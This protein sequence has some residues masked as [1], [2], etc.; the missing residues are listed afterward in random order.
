[1]RIDVSFESNGKSLSG[2]LYLPDGYEAGQTLPGV[3]VTGA[4]TTVKEQMPAIYAKAIS[5]R[6]FAALAFDFRGWGASP[7][8]VSYLEDPYRKTADILAATEYLNSRPE[9]DSARIAGLGICASSGYMSDAALKSERIQSL[10]LVAPWLHDQEI[11]DQVYGGPEGVTS[12]VKTGR[13]A[14]A[15]SEPLYIEAASNDNESA[16][17]Y[18]APYYTEP[19]RGLIPE[20][21]NKFNLASWEPWLTFDAMRTASQLNKPTILV[22]SDAA[23][24][25]QGVE[26]FADRMGENAKTIWLDDV[27]QFD[28]YDQPN[29]VNSSIELVVD[30]FRSSLNTDFGQS[31]VDELGIK[32]I[33][34]SVA[35]LAD[36]GNFESLEQHYAD[37]VEVDY[38]SLT[39]GDIEVT[40]PQKLMT[41][42]ASVLPGFDRTRH[43]VSELNIDIQG[44]SADAN[45]HVTASH[46][47]ANETWTVKGRYIYRLR[48]RDDRWQ[49]VYHRFEL[50]DEEGTR[51]VLG[52]AAERA[53]HSPSRYVVR[54]KTTDTVRKFLMSL[55]EKDMDK[56]ASVWAQDAVQ[57]M[58]YAPDGFPAQVTGKENILKH[59]AAW[60]DNSGPADFTSQLVFY[61]MIDPEMVFAEFKGIV[62]V[63][64]T[65]R[66]YQQ[67]YGGLFHVKNGE[68]TL[69]REYFN[70][71]PFVHAFGLDEGGE[72]R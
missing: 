7:D 46:F 69:F 16:L 70:P 3:V 9:V 27:T 58:P 23:A 49:I 13:D 17:M 62:E 37:E 67:S 47:I 31:I 63:I 54:Q 64:P 24:I 52:Q 51:D 6:G 50:T 59:Y 10:A 28:F 34:E 32:T 42:W 26:R 1:M 44:N 48:K 21:D 72:F 25:P 41:Q 55:E 33:V 19:D 15:K 14:A 2:H 56:F 29:A 11:V 38:T 68:I 18:Q 20:Y 35:L 60:P 66:T 65:Q 40:S 71:G 57:H 30:H 39:G 45:C 43:E 4:W 61:P 12:L 8:D 5:E 22:H 36:T 53:N